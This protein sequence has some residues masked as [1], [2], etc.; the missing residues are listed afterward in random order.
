[1]VIVC[2]R[3]FRV[4]CLASSRRLLL[5]EHLLGAANADT[6]PITASTPVG[7]SGGV[8]ATMPVVTST[9]VGAP[10]AVQQSTVNLKRAVQE[11][12]RAERKARKKHDKSL[13]KQA[14]LAKIAKV[15]E[16]AGSP[17]C[18]SAGEYR[19]MWCLPKDI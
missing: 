3:H 6:K 13:R 19:S 12:T 2:C 8:T 11:P 16:A 7:A 17:N 10:V 1:M 18:P 14:A 15:A 4:V 5:W 9:P